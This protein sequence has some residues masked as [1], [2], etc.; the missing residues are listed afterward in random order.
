MQ[1]EK[2]RRPHVA[3]VLQM[4]EIVVPHQLRLF[5]TLGCTPSLHNFFHLSG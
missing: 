5:F 1:K 4:R 3:E 2:N